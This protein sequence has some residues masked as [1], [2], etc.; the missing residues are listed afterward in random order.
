MKKQYICPQTLGSEI[1]AMVNLLAGS[2]NMRV[3]GQI[4][5][6]SIDAGNAGSAM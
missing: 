5:N 1:Q 6:G 3:A 4:F 2:N